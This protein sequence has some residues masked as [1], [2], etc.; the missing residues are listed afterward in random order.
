MNAG[1]ETLT[2]VSE[3]FARDVVDLNASVGNGL[4]ARDVLHHALLGTLHEIMPAQG[5]VREPDFMTIEQVPA[6]HGLWCLLCI[7]LVMS[8]SLL[9]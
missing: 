2:N 6:P 4:Y 9:K 5:S 8:W 3:V 1:R 7:S